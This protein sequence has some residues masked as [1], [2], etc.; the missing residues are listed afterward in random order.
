MVI[1]QKTFNFT[2]V[3]KNSNERLIKDLEFA[4]ALIEPKGAYGI[5]IPG[6]VVD[7]IAAIKQ[8]LELY[9][10]FK[11]YQKE[12]SVETS[13]EL[14]GFIVFKDATMIPIDSDSSPDISNATEIV[15]EIENAI[16]QYAYVGISKINVSNVWKVLTPDMQD[17]KV[18]NEDNDPQLVPI[19][20]ESIKKMDDNELI[21]TFGTLIN[22][23]SDKGSEEM[24]GDASLL[25]DAFLELKSRYYDS[26][27]DLQQVNN[28]FNTFIDEYELHHLFEK[29]IDELKELMS[30]NG[31]VKDSFGD[32]DYFMKKY[33]ESDR[34]I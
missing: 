33:Y 13:P 32:I 20:E 19:S 15:W 9:Q 31:E 3:D 10:G 17:E 4:I 16:D 2:G 34:K 12:V 7:S 24:E 29:Y 25:Y 18:I 1:D 5:S 23:T 21:D 11:D 22:W 30:R 8:R 14:L 28:T 6:E 26:Q 27:Y